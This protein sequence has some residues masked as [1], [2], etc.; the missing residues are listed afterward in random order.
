[1]I[2]F[3]SLGV[4]VLGLW[5]LGAGKWLSSYSNTNAVQPP[6]DKPA[7]AVVDQETQRALFGAPRL[8]RVGV[9]SLRGR[10]M[11]FATTEP[12]AGLD[13]VL[14]GSSHAGLGVAERVQSDGRGY[15]IFSNAAAGDGYTLHVERGGTTVRQ[16][17][18]V[19]VSVETEADLG[20]IWLGERGALEGRLVDGEGRGV[21]EAAVYARRS[22][23]PQMG[24]MRNSSD[25]LAALDRPP[26]TLAVARS[27]AQG[28]FR[29]ADVDP[30]RIALDVQAAGYG[31]SL[32][33]VVMT[34]A[35][36]GGGPLVVA[37]D[38]CPPLRGRVVDE[39]GIGI[40]GASVALCESRHYE[41]G[42]D[43]IVTLQTGHDGRFELLAPPLGPLLECAVAVEGRP[44]LAR[45]VDGSRGHLELVSTGGAALLVRLTLDGGAAAPADTM[46][47]L[48]GG[49]AGD[50][51]GA[52]IA[53]GL[54]NDS[55]EVVLQAQPNRLERVF[56]RHPRRG[57]G[58][59]LLKSPQFAIAPDLLAKH[60]AFFS[61][62]VN[63]ALELSW[64]TAG[65]IVGHVRSTD[66]RPLQGVRV[67]ALGMMC[68]GEAVST[69]EEGA[70]VLPTFGPTAALAATFPGYV[71][72]Y[73]S[74]TLEEDDVARDPDGR[75][76]VDLVMQPAGRLRG[77]VVDE[78][79]KP[80]PGAEV[81]F[82]GTTPGLPG[83][84]RNRTITNAAGRYL[85]DGLQEGEYLQVL[86][87][88]I[89]YVDTIS[90][91]VDIVAGATGTVAD[92]VM[93]RGA[94]L[95]V[96][97]CDSSGAP[98]AGARLQVHATREGGAHGVYPQN[99]HIQ[100]GSFAERIANSKG[101]VQVANLAKGRVTLTASA[102]GTG[103]ARHVVP[104]DSKTPTTP[105][106]VV[107]VLRD[108]TSLAGRVVDSVGNSL[109][110]ALI[111]VEGAEQIYPP[112]SGR[113]SR[114][115]GTPVQSGPMNDWI[116]S[117]S[118]TAD[119]AGRFHL[120]DLP[121][122]PLP[123]HVSLVGY[124]PLALQWAGSRD[125]A[126]LVLEPWSAAEVARRA[127]LEA[128]IGSAVTA[129]LEATDPKEKRALGARMRTLAE[130]LAQLGG[131]AR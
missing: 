25:F 57:S 24:W 68:A 125:H 89:G 46:I 69:N 30:G 41:S 112:Y 71:H 54:T 86:A 91:M 26:P 42:V 90:N 108:G 33:H 36:V 129:W 11:D 9:A 21:P 103:G 44:T 83:E 114:G 5:L 101:S 120:A 80:V 74:L 130:E 93:V 52:W 97:V 116:P 45:R 96:T 113:V 38:A 28:H 13:I 104:I 78:S 122:G 27:D 32:T 105:R 22:A 127:E 75:R 3:A 2:V 98:I 61:L 100:P 85:L 40:G 7:E 119:A 67:V 73:G 81:V 29:L 59:Y 48:Y 60:A 77:R 47:A 6:V 12:V 110:G 19:Y 4:V 56:V 63:N 65:G 53:S 15:F 76:V 115:A 18:D 92:I 58:S 88:C 79:G 124:R 49:S 123:L 10:I 55:G 106:E 118:A 72:G 17:E 39:N 102:P 117:R 62:P 64:P 128:E 66:G 87:S 34:P 107:V 121:A 70:Y 1:M 99:L 111:E 8:G 84:L 31:R 94:A 95:E 51:A 23:V 50:I 109:P 126:E 14:G 37:L 43:A 20:D 35:G 82:V 16:L 131:S